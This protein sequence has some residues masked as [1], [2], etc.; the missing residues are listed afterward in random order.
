VQFGNISDLLQADLVDHFVSCNFSPI[1]SDCHGK[2]STVT[3][4]LLVKIILSGV[5]TFPSSNDRVCSLVIELV[6]YL[7]TQKGNDVLLICVLRSGA[8]LVVR[9]HLA[10]GHFSVVESIS[11]LLSLPSGKL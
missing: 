4:F 9:N 1:R 3:A 2:V 10:R 6:T 11:R 8:L 5:F 7:K